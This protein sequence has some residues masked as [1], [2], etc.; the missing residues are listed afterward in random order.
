MKRFLIKKQNISGQASLEFALV[1]PFLIFIILIVFQLGYIVYMQNIAEHAAHEGTR[2]IATTNSNSKAESVI[3]DILKR[4]DEEKIEINISPPAQN[5]R[6]TGD[7]V[8]LE[9]KYMYGGMA[10]I[11]KTITGRSILIKGNCIMRMEC[12]SE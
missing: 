1:V 2:I 7:L 12:G 10:E 9:V 5:Q 4:T 6:K 11:I 8:R 3:H